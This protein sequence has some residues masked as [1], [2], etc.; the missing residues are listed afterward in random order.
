MQIASN[1]PCYEEAV[2]VIAQVND[3]N[4][5]LEKELQVKSTQVPNYQP[6][7]QWFDK[8]DVQLSKHTAK[9]QG[10]SI[11]DQCEIIRKDEIPKLLAAWE[12]YY[13]DLCSISKVYHAAFLEIRDSYCD[14]LTA[15]FLGKGKI[16]LKKLNKLKGKL[17]KQRD[18]TQKISDV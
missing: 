4:A 12:K 16:S 5:Q 6:L 8:I 7:K 2:K 17:A 9:I 13:Q 15:S 18:A 14:P 1:S 3:K 11:R 10:K